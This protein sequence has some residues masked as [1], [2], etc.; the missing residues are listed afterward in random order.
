MVEERG[1]CDWASKP[2]EYCFPHK[3]RLSPPRYVR[4]DHQEA[5]KWVY[6]PFRGLLYEK[7][8]LVLSIGEMCA[9]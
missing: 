6:L 9:M 2:C 4:Y 8:K 7:S 3:N 5:A 1:L